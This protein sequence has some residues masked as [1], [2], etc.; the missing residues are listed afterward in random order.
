M[1]YRILRHRSWDRFF[2]GFSP[3]R[4]GLYLTL[5]LLLAS[6]NAIKRVAEDENLLEDNTVLENG[7]KLNSSAIEGYLLQKP[8]SKVLGMPVR[9]Y[10]YNWAKPPGTIHQPY[11]DRKPG[12]EEWWMNF[13]SK[14]QVDEWGRSKMGFH[15][16]LRETGE[17]PVI[18]D[19]SRTRKTTERLYKVYFNRGYFNAKSSYEIIPSTKKSSRAS[20]TYRIETGKPYFVD[21]VAVSM[22]SPDLD[23]IYQLVAQGSLV[24]QGDL[25]RLTNFEAERERLTTIFLNSGVFDF[26]KSSI[27]YDAR[28]DTTG[29]DFKVPVEM[30]INNRLRRTPESVEEIPYV[31]HKVSRV[32]ILTDDSYRNKEQEYTDSTI[33]KGIHIYSKGKLRYRPK[34]LTDPVFITP[35]EVFR[36]IDR[37]QT[38]KQINNLRNFKYPNIQYTYADSTRT[39]LVANILLTPR[40]RYSLGFD[41]DLLHS[42]IQDFG[43]SF[44]T[45]L[46]SRNIFGGA[47]NLE[48][49]LR[50]TVGASRNAANSNNTFFNVLEF[51]GD[52]RLNFPRFFLPFKT[53]KWVPKYMSPSSFISIGS[54]IQT[55]IGLDKQNLISVFNYNWEP[56]KFNTHSVDLINAEYVN[57][58]N[59]DNYFN[60]Y[61]NSYDDLNSIAMDSNY[62]VTN[63]EDFDENGNLIIPEGTDNFLLVATDPENPLDLSPEDQQDVNAIDER[64]TRLTDNN[65]IVGTN[66][67]FRKNTKENVLDEDFYQFRGRIG[68]AGNSLWA[69]SQLFGASRNENGNFEVFGLEFSQFVK[70]ELDYIKHWSLSRNRVVAFRSFLGIAIPYGNANNIPFSRSYFAG[71]SNDNRAWEA[72]SL[73][74]GSS[75]SNDEFNEANF[76]LAFNLEYRY[77]LFGSLKGAFFA[78]A[79]NIWHVWDNVQDEPSRFTSFKDLGELG[80]GTGFGLRYDFDF[81]VFRFDIGFKT[82]DPGLPIGDRWFTDYNFSN[83]TY[84]IGINYPF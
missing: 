27:R 51:G 80:L 9:L 15:N 20:V 16:W 35:G 83:A 5:M 50:G 75:V 40:R 24:R 54:G 14:K 79:G 22:K 66:Y 37:S 72:Y 8:N 13:L 30:K 58:R 11:L 4:T 7:E 82:Y 53:D 32:N 48:F 78:D 1:L 2:F 21:S 61:T 81:L 41:F 34:A 39:D 31:V 59:P 3:T 47:E 52:L 23:S 36:D 33:Y 43:I 42:N 57:N 70:F 62:V 64:K 18:I 6:C 84:N 38:L 77:T 76:K 63:P 67:L 73:G 44:R 65:L 56:T 29:V 12:R 17:E 49:A 68:L 71:G 60:V 55:N 19:T 26:Q 10:I 28:W 45:S 74:P 46:V 69:L 25:F